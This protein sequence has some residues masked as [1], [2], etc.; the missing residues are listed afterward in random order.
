MS[1]EAVVLAALHANA[2]DDTCWLALAD[3]LEENG[4][5]ER[6]EITRLLTRLRR[7]LDHS[8]R[9]GWEERLRTLLAAEVRPCVPEV[10]NSLGMRLALIPPGLFWMGGPLDERSSYA[11]ERPRHAVE[12]THAFYLGVFP[13]TQGQYE[14][15][16]GSNPSFF[17]WEQAGAPVPRLPKNTT[18]FPVENV[19]WAD[20]AAFCQRLSKLPTEKKAG[21]SYRLPTEAEWEYA[22]RAG[23]TT[24]FHFGNSGSATLA[25]FDARS[26]YGA[27]EPESFLGRTCAVG[28]YLPN[29]F[30]LYDMH[31]N[32]N[33]WCSDWFSLGYYG[34]SPAQDPRGP[35]SGLKKALRGGCWNFFAE[36]CRS[37]YRAANRRDEHRRY[38]GFRVVLKFSR[39]HRP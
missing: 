38:D 33:E 7:T 26:D 12:L 18:D 8:E 4:Q 15:V 2:A 3:A 16:M 17:K 29:G 28:S 34:R 39:S 20:A 25:N 6:A 9:P 11:D 1:S 23:T 5:S 10:V 35:R 22:C 27:K 19:S 21:R 24:A 30:G 31:G 36:N 32:V 13:V 37:A 14:T